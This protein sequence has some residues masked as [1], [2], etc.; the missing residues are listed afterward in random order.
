[1]EIRITDGAGYLAVHAVGDLT[2]RTVPDLRDGLLKAAAEQPRGLICDLRDV[3]ATRE[4]LT[5]LHV[6]ADQV[7]DWPGSPLAV[8]ARDQPLLD[9]LGVLGLR[10]RLPVVPDSDQASAALRY[11]PRFLRVAT[12]LDPTV[13]APAAARAFAGEHLRRWQVDEAVEPAQWVVSELVTN[14][15]VHA[16]TELTVRVSLSGRVGVAVGDRGTGRIARAASEGADT[17]WGLTV[18]EQLSRS[19]GVLPRMGDG[20]VVW[21]VLDVDVPTSRALP[22]QATTHA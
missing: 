5:I 20:V 10:R 4:S 6:V 22:L 1:M 13:D 15:V 9:Q 8:V 12:R 18:V 11:S 19:W 3:R 2:L 14:A 17:G 7:A 16:G 21:A